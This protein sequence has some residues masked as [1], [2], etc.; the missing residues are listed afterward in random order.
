LVN[1]ADRSYLR[2]EIRQSRDVRKLLNL[3]WMPLTPTG[4][5]NELLSKPKYLVD[6]APML[7]AAEIKT[8]L[9]EAGTPF[10][11]ADVPLIDEAAVAVGD[12]VADAG[13]G[14]KKSQQRNLDTAEAA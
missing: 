2:Q 4:L 10:T 5:V 14:T 6:A 9:R 3:C 12:L 7:S 11:E 13:Q 8:L 1:K